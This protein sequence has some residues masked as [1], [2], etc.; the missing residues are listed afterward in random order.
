MDQA[1]CCCPRLFNALYKM[2]HDARQKL[3]SVLIERGFTFD[4][5]AP[6]FESS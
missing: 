6:L 5:V 2:V 1:W 4:R 3:R